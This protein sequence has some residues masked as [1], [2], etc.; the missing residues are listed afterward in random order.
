MRGKQTGTRLVPLGMSQVKGRL[1]GIGLEGI[2]WSE[3]KQRHRGEDS[4]CGETRLSKVDLESWAQE[5]GL[6]LEVVVDQS[7]RKKVTQGKL[8][9]PV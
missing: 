9:P 8:E 7:L 3:P 5:F 2:G 4:V 6:V 1:E